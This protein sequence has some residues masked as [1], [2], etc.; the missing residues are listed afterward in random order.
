D[1]INLYMTE[2]SYQL[3]FRIEKSSFLSKELFIVKNGV[4]PY[5]VGKGKPTQT[6][7][8]LTIKPFTSN[9]K[10]DDSFTLL[11]GGS[12]FNKYIILWRKDFW[13]K[14]GE[15]LAEPR[16]REDFEAKKKLIFRQTSDKL[17]GTFC[18]DFFVM[19][20]NRHIILN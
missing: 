1:Y 10:V 14:Y 17:I 12:S 18:T 9:I 4:K 15:W 11:I 20:D 8:I 19:R 13:I 16:N 2:K 5:E 6:K 3:K 7:E